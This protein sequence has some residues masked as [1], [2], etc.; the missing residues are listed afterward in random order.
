MQ[1]Y[2]NQ[3][4]SSLSL[5]QL[6]NASDQ[7]QIEE[8]QGLKKTELSGTYRLAMAYENIME[9]LQE[10]QSLVKQDV[11]DALRATEALKETDTLLSHSVSKGGETP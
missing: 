5:M 11:A 6:R 8:M 7:L 2:I 4:K 1:I 3:E 9:L 10:F